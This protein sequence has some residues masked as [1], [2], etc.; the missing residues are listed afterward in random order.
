MEKKERYI[1]IPLYI[2]EI[3]NENIK[4]NEK[5]L[6]GL[7]ESLSN[8][9]SFCWAQDSHLS[10]ALGLSPRI[11]Q[12]ALKNLKDSN[13]ITIEKVYEKGTK[14]C[15][16]RKISI[17]QICPEHTE[18]LDVFGRSSRQIW[19][20]PKHEALDKF[21][22]DNNKVKN[23]R[24]EDIMEEDKKNITVLEKCEVCGI[25]TKIQILSPDAKERIIKTKCNCNRAKDNKVAN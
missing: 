16:K 15:T 25:M 22:V 14:V 17:R 20:L 10:E 4:S 21:V 7:I 24:K 19:F 5:L 13:L 6:Y 23:K 3:D 12:R 8:K 1:K 2:L 11:I 18:A 9:E